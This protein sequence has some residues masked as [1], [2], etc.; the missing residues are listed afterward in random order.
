MTSGPNNSKWTVDPALYGLGCGDTSCK[1]IPPVGGMATNGG[2]RCYTNKGKDVERFLLRNIA[3]SIDLQKTR[4][5]DWLPID[6]ITNNEAI[7]LI[8]TEF[9]S[10][11]TLGFRNRKDNKFY[12]NFGEHEEIVSGKVTGW[13]P[14]PQGLTM[15][16]L[17]EP[18]LPFEEIDGED[19]LESPEPN[20]ALK[21]LMKGKE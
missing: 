8:E 9:S 15:E 2:C 4:R 6:T 11:T 1:Y 3:M 14:L 16:E 12:Y 20:E 5:K 17:G 7:L 21:K 18:D 13:I 10:W 19:F